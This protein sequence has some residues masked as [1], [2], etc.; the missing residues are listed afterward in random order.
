MGFADLF[1]LEP[2]DDNFRPFRLKNYVRQLAGPN[3]SE[4]KE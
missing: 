1:S 4:I 3:Y 2:V